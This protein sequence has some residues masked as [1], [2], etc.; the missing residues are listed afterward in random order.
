MPIAQRVLVIDDE[1][2]VRTVLERVLQR[3]GF[4][5]FS[6]NTGEGAVE[7]C[8]RDHPDLVIL[9]LYLP[10][11]PGEKVCQEIREDE[12][13]KAVPILILTG[14]NTEG[15]TARCLNLGAD[16][17]LAKPFNVDELVARIRAVLRRP[18]IYAADNI[19]VRSGR[20]SV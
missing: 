6:L 18:R 1:A 12:T 9:D 4:Q 7:A 16:D 15:L 3:E 19:L 10:G 11:H 2:A 5:V 8:R 13:V 20:V 17:Y 14:R